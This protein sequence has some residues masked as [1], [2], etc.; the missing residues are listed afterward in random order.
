[1]KLKTMTESTQMLSTAKPKGLF[2][3][4]GEELRLRGTKALRP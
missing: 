3:A 1:M 2:E 4:V